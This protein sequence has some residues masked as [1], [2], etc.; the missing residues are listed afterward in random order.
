V[1]IK[2]G[3]LRWRGRDVTGGGARRIAW[4]TLKLERD[5]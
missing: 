5:R 2:V 3:G 4:R 1:R